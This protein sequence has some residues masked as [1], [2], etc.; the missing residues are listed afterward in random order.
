MLKN[1]ANKGKKLSD[2]H[3]K[4]I[5]ESRKKWLVEN[6]DKHPWKF[7]KKSVPCEFFKEKLKNENIKFEEEVSI[8][9]ERHYSVD[10]LLPDYNLI[11]EI[12]GN[13]HYNSDKTLT[14]YYQERHDFIKNLGWEILEVH[15]SSVY[16]SHFIIEAIKKRNVSVIELFFEIKSKNKVSKVKEKKYSGENKRKKEKLRLQA[17]KRRN[18]RNEKNIKLIIE[19]K[20]SKIDFNHKNWFLEASKILELKTNK[21]S[22]WMKKNMLQF[23]EQNCFK[24]Y[25]N[26]KIRKKG[27]FSEKL[28][29]GKI[30]GMSEASIVYDVRDRFDQIHLGRVPR[31]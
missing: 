9:T 27:Q 23:Y 28:D 3:K 8:S 18:D 25:P 31:Y 4:K 13:Q 26:R 24:R 19:I 17:E 14:K 11:I 30:S 20:N 22:K 29:A 6:P 7:K 10:I 12:N 21:V 16:N 1:K 2:E 5:S 15:Y